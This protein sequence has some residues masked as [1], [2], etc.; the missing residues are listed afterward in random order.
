MRFSSLEEAVRALFGNDRQIQKRRSVSGGDINDAYALELDDGTSVFL[1]SNAAAALPN[2]ES[3]SAG[4]AAIQKTGTI[5]TPAVLG[6]GTDPSGFSFL[7]LSLIRPGVQI[8]GYWETFGRE[9]AAMHAAVPE[10]GGRYGF[11]AD[12]YIG[13]R[14][15]INTWH[16]SWTAFFRDC[17]LAGQFRDAAGYFDPSD[18]KRITRLLDHLD[19]ILLEPERPSLIHGDLW[20]GNFM[21]G[22]DGKAW[23][24]DPA[25]YYGHPEA[26]LAMTELFGGFSP[27]FY[28]SYRESRPLESGYPDRREIYNLYHLLNHLN[29]FGS[30]Y[31]P[32]VRRILK[33][34]GGIL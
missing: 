4:L 21:T 23:L 14:K 9:L 6:C 19:E 15:Q 17:R 18:R 16:D 25:V 29:M 8:R 20:A 13:H 33:R 26:D 3:E 7:L 2:F 30:S 11:A 31:L 28:D 10:K 32:S 12:N 22:D 34:F 24:I 5:Q 1:K 27:A